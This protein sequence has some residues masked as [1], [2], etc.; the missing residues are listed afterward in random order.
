MMI[1]TNYR[2]IDLHN[3]I[4]LGAPYLGP[5]NA[6]SQP[7]H[8][9][10]VGTSYIGSFVC[11]PV[12][13]YWENIEFEEDEDTSFYGRIGLGYNSET[14]THVLV[15]TSYKEKNMECKLRYVEEKEWRP[16]DPPPRPI[17]NTP[18][19]YVNG[20]IC[21]LVEPNLLEGSPSCEIVAFDA[22]SE[23]FKVLQGP[24]YCSHPVGRMSILCL[25]RCTLCGLLEPEH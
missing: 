13:S 20:T 23:E 15:L 14:S 12:M 10:N 25:Q 19:T 24:Q 21:W 4:A 3:F 22:Q 8:G 6:C 18:P 17:A 5:S 1:I 9:L 2:C 11:N 16:I 7:C